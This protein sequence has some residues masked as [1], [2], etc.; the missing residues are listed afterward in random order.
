[1]ARWRTR[2][3][4]ATFADVPS[5]LTGRAL[6]EWLEERGLSVVDYFAWLRNQD[7]EAAQ[8]PPARRKLMTQK[9]VAKLDAEI[10]REGKP[11][12]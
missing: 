6:T 2:D 12:W 11:L 10:E 9:Q 4:A 1:M 7:P 3:P 5:D 8:R